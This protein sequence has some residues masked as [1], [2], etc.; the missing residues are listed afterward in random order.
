MMELVSNVHAG[1]GVCSLQINL[2]ASGQ[3]CFAE[4][5]AVVCGDFAV[6]CEIDGRAKGGLLGSDLGKLFAYKEIR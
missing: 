5:H 2:A 3:I 6:N 4:C 1:I